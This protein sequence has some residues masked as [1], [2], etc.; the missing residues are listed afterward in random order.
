MLATLKTA[1]GCSRKMNVPYP[2]QEYIII[3]L[4]YPPPLKLDYT[5]VPLTI[6][7]PTRRFVLNTSKSV[8]LYS[9]SGLPVYEEEQ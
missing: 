1:C 4:I 6:P 3:P 7:C 2:A 5:N 9:P 8:N